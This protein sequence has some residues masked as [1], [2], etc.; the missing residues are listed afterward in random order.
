MFKVKYLKV[1]RFIMFANN[2]AKQGPSWCL[3]IPCLFSLCRY[4]GDSTHSI[5]KSNVSHWD[6]KVFGW[7]WM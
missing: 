3:D 7:V 1:Q 5:K 4:G 6:V 2:T